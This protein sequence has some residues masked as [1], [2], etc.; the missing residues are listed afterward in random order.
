MFT[1]PVVPKPGSITALKWESRGPTLLQV[2]SARVLDAKGGKSTQLKFAGNTKLT[3]DDK[4]VLLGID[5]PAKLV[6]GQQLEVV[7]RTANLNRL[8]LSTTANSTALLR[9]TLPKERPRQLEQFR[10]QWSGF[11]KPREEQARLTKEKK[12]VDSTAPVTMIAS[13]TAKMRSGFLLVRGA[14]DKR[15]AAVQ[16]AAPASIM[17][18]PKSLPANR[19]GLARWLTDP[20]NPLTARVVVNRYW[21]MCFGVGIVKTSEDLGTQ[22]ELPAHPALLDH[23]SVGFVAS[24]WD[25]KALLRKLVTSATYRQSSVLPDGLPRHDPENRWLARGPRRV[26]ERSVAIWLWI[27]PI[28]RIASFAFHE[29]EIKSNDT[30]LPF[31]SLVGDRQTRIIFSD[32]LLA[33]K[34]VS[35]V[36]L[37]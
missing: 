9:A 30:T 20:A 13:D 25:V 3:L 11:Q 19:V 2:V 27:L 15:G 34:I 1:L 32:A 5:P 10:K 16:T 17:A 7:V 31:Y 8:R 33:H 35:L 18:F 4:P 24:G 28:F 22:G 6:A 36:L 14:Y 23:L 12:Q 21:Q 29:T 37:F 26:E